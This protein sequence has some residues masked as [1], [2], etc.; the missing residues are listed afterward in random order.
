MLQLGQNSTINQAIH[1]FI[2]HIARNYIYRASFRYCH[3]TAISQH[4]CH[5]NA[6]ND[7]Q[8]VLFD[9][10]CSNKTVAGATIN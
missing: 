6:Q 3:L 9:Q 4:Y 1:R 2:S 8:L 5:A 7:S 10:L